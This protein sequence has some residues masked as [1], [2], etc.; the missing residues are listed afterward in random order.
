MARFVL[1]QLTLLRMF[2]IVIGRI[3]MELLRVEI[4]VIV[5]SSNASN[6]EVRSALDLIPYHDK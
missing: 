1:R 2:G 6:V 5:T 4:G 3:V